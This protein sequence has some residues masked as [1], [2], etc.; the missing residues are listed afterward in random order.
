MSGA[1]RTYG[2]VIQHLGQKCDAVNEDRTESLMRTCLHEMSAQLC[3]CPEYQVSGTL[4]IEAGVCDY[5]LSSLIENV[6]LR[7][8]TQLLMADG[9][10][11][12]QIQNEDALARQRAMAATGQPCAFEIWGNKVT[13]YPTP[14]CDECVLVH[15]YRCV[16]D[17]LYDIEMV[18]PQGVDKAGD[19]LPDVEVRNWKVIDL[20]SGFHAAFEN[21]V[22]GLALCEAGDTSQGTKWLELASS[23]FDTQKEQKDKGQVQQSSGV[24]K[25]DNWCHKKKPC[26]DDCDPKDVWNG[27]PVQADGYE[28]REAE[29]CH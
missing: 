16:N 10:V 25:M 24:G 29:H 3:E 22:I 20:P 23:A 28:L 6:E 18:T 7:A 8:I 17:S 11:L 27:Q 13:L 2:Q 19:P 26:A 5:E 12:D 21:C 1:D 14:E 4:N 15:G 9:T